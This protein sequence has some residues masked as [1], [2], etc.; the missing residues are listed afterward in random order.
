MKLKHVCL[1]LA[2]ALL[3]AAP[4]QAQ[5]KPKSEPMYG[6]RMMTPQ[7]RDEYRAKMRNAKSAEER[8]KIRAEHQASMKERMGAGMGPG[9]G[10][11]G[12]GGGMG[13]GGMG[14]GK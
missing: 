11:M 10:M 2:A 12:P 13:P 3:P 7:E 9:G 4:I 5:D 14:R 1:V 6:Y 8:E